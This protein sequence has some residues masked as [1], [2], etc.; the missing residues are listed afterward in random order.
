MSRQTLKQAA[1]LGTC[2][3]ILAGPPLAGQTERVRPAT[4]HLVLKCGTVIDPGSGTVQKDVFIEIVSGKILQIGRLA[5]LGSTAEAKVLDFSGKYVIPGLID[6]HAHL[7]GG[8]AARHATNDSHAPMYL[9]CGVTTIRAPGS[10]NPEG[11]LA[12]K[13][14]IDAGACEGPRIYLSGAYVEMHPPTVGWMN[15]L[16]TPEEVRLTI[17]H[18][19][20]RGATS[21]KLYASM[22]GDLM[23]AAIGHAH[24]HGL[25][26]IAHIG[27][28]GY[29]ESIRAGIDEIFHGVAVISDLVPPGVDQR[30]Y[31]DWFKALLA[32][33]FGRPEYARILKLAAE[34]K[35]VLTPTAA[36]FEEFGPASEAMA[37][38]KP[39]Y[40]AAAWDALLKKAGQKP[41]V[42]GAEKITAMNLRFVGDA[43]RAG[44]VLTTGTDKTNVVP[45]P[46]FSLWQEMDAFTRAGLPP[47]A[48]LKAATANGAY[49]LALGDLIGSIASGRLAD[50]VV[51]DRNPLDAVSNVSAVHRVIK[52]GV[53]Y[54]PEALLKRL[55]GRIE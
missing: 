46:G 50:L 35:T 47:M 5:D 7:Y 2:W 13:H 38:Q 3:A 12:L 9:A 37:R 18:W 4:D 30:Q 41:L 6:T 32:L 33:D 28:A 43:F 14:R 19:A 51:L 20:E 34:T 49:A 45:L 27:A 17:D 39:Y 10:G 25:K 40:S 53:V 29:E 48:V 11:D 31:F 52:A 22:K 26:A 15:A 24:A 55:L 36:A 1:I 8:V 21:I 23:K 44:C 16:R 42:E 54:E